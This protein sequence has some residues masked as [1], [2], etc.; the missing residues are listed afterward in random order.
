MFG[1]LTASNASRV[2]IICSGKFTQQAIDFALSKS[3][4]Y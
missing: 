4:P 3:I 2:F 1:V